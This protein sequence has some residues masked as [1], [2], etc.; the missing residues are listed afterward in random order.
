VSVWRE[1][2]INRLSIGIQSFNDAVLQWMHR[3]HD[4]A[5]AEQAVRAAR[6]AGIR[7]LSIDLIFALP[8]ALNRNWRDDL[9]RAL[10]LEPE[11]I[12]LYGLT[13]EP[14]T[15]LGRW[16][17]SGLVAEAPEGGYEEQFLLAHALLTGAG[18][19]HY[20]VSNFAKPGK[21]A[22]HN[23]A[24]WGGASYL[25]AGPSA[26]G[27]DGRTRRWNVAPYAG[28]LEQVGN[29]AD[30]MAGSEQLSPANHLTEAV[31]LGLRTRDG[32]AVTQA[33]QPLVSR[34]VRAGWLEF[35]DAAN[36]LHVRCTPEGWLRLDGLAADLTALRS[37]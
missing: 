3:V 23:S 37:Y 5:A 8:A 19:E 13:V 26:H 24:Y 28:W 35:P 2:G 36:E 17:A 15:P 25:G 32:L 18:Y 27:F 21:R 4:A 16:T 34:W 10:A 6:E 29:G 22:V 1:A 7:A 30:P 20:E 12:S 31:Y 11:H 9:A 33:D 14:Q